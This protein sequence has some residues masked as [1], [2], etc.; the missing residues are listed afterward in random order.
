MPH[1]GY[2]PL[3]IPADWEVAK[4]HALSRRVAKEK[5]KLPG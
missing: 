1:E 4:K 3:K 5:T 2:N